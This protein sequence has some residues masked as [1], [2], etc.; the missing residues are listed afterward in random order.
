MGKRILFVDDDKD[1]RFLLETALKD[2]G[3]SIETAQDATEALGKAEEFQPELVI[4]DLNLAGEDGLM[5]MKFLKENNPGV[6][7]MLY[8]GMDEDAESI[9]RALEQGAYSYVRKG[10]P[11]E[12]LRE[13]ELVFQ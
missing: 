12:L 10:S 6:R 2:A 1:W 3:Y 8:T 13:I 9:M 7:I 4:V 5:L 11:E